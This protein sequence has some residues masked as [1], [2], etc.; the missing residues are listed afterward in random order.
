[1]YFLDGQKI[2]KKLSLQI[3]KETKKIRELL[4]KYNACTNVSS[5]C[6]PLEMNDATKLTTIMDTTSISNSKR[7]LIE[8]FLRIKRSEEEIVMLESEM[9]NTVDHYEHEVQAVVICIDK[10]VHKRDAFSRGALALLYPHLIK[11]QTRLNE[12]HYFH[13]IM[14]HGQSFPTAPE[15]VCY[16]DSDLEEEESYSE[17]T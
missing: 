4:P 6:S 12:S 17:E 3:S 1:M 11:L 13:S 16:S 15:A 5:E 7:E 9:S 2:S 14:K 8:T 10:C